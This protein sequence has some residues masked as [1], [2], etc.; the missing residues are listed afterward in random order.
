MRSNRNCS[1]GQNTS[2]L[3]TLK[4]KHCPESED[5]TVVQSV[6]PSGKLVDRI[7]AYL[8]GGGMFNPELALH[9][10]VRDLLIDARDELQKHGALHIIE[11][12]CWDLRCESSRGCTDDADDVWVVYSHH[13][14]EPKLRREGSGRTPAEA[15]RN[16]I[17]E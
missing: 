12:E 6:S 10:A 11:K 13:M 3:L 5:P 4:S 9:D 7:N 2:A 8:L 14:Q 17:N 15:V 16:A 1:K